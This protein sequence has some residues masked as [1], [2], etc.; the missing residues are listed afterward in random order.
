MGI[1]G[2][3]WKRMGIEGLGE[4]EERAEAAAS[5]RPPRRNLSSL[6]ESSMRVWQC[7]E[8]TSGVCQCLGFKIYAY[9]IKRSAFLCFF[10]VIIASVNIE[11][12]LYLYTKNVQWRLRTI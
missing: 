11:Y 10:S 7:G 9:L 2:V 12:L 8:T 3:E 6:E 4:C 1:E 5:S